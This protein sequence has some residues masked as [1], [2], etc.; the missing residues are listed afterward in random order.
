M[1]IVERDA[2]DERSGWNREK[3]FIFK[4]IYYLI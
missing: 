2:N 1:G 4:S 3:K